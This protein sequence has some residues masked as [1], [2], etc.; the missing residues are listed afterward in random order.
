METAGE[1]P[2]TVGHP[3]DV[4]SGVVYTAWHDFEFP[5]FVPLIWRRFYSTGNRALTPL[6]LGWWSLFFMEVRRDGDFWLLR[7]E[8]G[9]EI[10]FPVPPPGQA[11]LNPSAQMELRLT[12][13]GCKIWYWHHQQ[14]FDFFFRRGDGTLA[15]TKIEDYS[16]NSIDLEYD[17]RQR[18]SELRQS[19]VNRGVLLRYQDR[20]LIRQIDFVAPGAA[21]EPLV[22]YGHG[23]GGELLS[24][25]DPHGHAMSYQYDQ[26]FRLVRETG[27]LG[28]SFDF[29]YDEQGRCVESVGDGGYLRRVLHYDSERKVNSVTNSLGFTTLYHYN[30]AGLVDQTIFPDN[31]IIQRI[32]AP[33]MR[34]KVL[35]R[36]ETTTRQLDEFGNVIKHIDALGQ[37]R[38]YTYDP[39]RRCTRMT[40]PDG[41]V[42]QWKYDDR[43]RLMGFIDPLGSQ[44]TLERGSLGEIT[45]QLDPEGGE[46]LRRW[47]PAWDRQEFVNSAGFFRCEYDARGRCV[48]NADARGLIVTFER[49]RNGRLVSRRLPDGSEVRIQYDPAGNMTQIRFPS[50]EV[51]SYQFDRFSHLTKAIFPDGGEVTCEY[52]SEGRCIGMRNQRGEQLINEYD[53]HGRLI[54]RQSFNGT[55]ETYEYDLSGNAVTFIRSDGSQLLR[56][57]NAIRHVT[58]EWQRL[59][60]T[61]PELLATFEYDWHGRLRKASNNAGQN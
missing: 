49:D 53:F 52:D 29:R 22:T 3:V 6:G 30:D 41:A 23:P 11:S 51:W 38:E 4:V 24:A 33:G 27:R 8:E 1:S 35:A 2:V 26:Q 39:M 25:T 32:R 37:V 50:G 55:T 14:Y 58:E 56:S 28:G 57:Y 42:R 36:G 13:Q 12:D 15:L 61:E 40:T 21:P 16:G 18:L 31:S 7:N 5:G 44:W 59:A 60:G 54:R 48:S 45:R 10:P 46:L 43:G 19:A 17:R 47:S 9:R 34:Q 20:D